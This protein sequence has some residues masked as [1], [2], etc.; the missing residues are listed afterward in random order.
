MDKKNKS[1]NLIG[2]NKKNDLY[3]KLE[4]FLPAFRIIVLIHEFGNQKYAKFSWQNN[5]KESFSTV[6]S[7]I[8]SILNHYLLHKTGQYYDVETKLCHLG[9]MACR[10]QM[11]LTEFYRQQQP[12][13]F[14]KKTD[15]RP[16]VN[17]IL[18]RFNLGTLEDTFISDQITE[19][20]I[21][22]ASKMPK[23]VLKMSSIEEIE[24]LVWHFIMLIHTEDKQKKVYP[25]DI[26]NT[27]YTVDL[28]FW[29][30]CILYNDFINKRGVNLVPVK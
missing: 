17:E 3:D 5:P 27:I 19:E 6:S 12:H 7:S 24:T 10:C 28:L 25:N 21:I 15:V 1:V 16:K 2:F 18:T 30:I 26:W 29:H 20:L 22:S 23:D 8:G 9:H 13:Y 4:F 11:L 14:K